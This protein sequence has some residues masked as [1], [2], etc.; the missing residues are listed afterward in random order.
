[1]FNYGVNPTVNNHE[2]AMKTPESFY[3]V[4]STVISMV[5]GLI[6]VFG[7]ACYESYGETLEDVVTLNLPHNAVTSTV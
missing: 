6:I 7:C 1:M 2:A 5:T 4:N 3:C